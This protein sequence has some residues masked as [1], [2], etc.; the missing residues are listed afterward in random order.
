MK[1]IIF[2]SCIL[3]VQLT[4]AQDVIF[5]FDGTTIESKVIAIE[6]E[7]IKY[8][9]W[10]S[11][12]DSIYSIPKTEVIMINYANG[13]RDMFVNNESATQTPLFYD[14]N[15]QLEYDKESFSKLRLGNKLLTER[16]AFLLLS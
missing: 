11:E 12:E 5:I 2:L 14:A 3:F 7:V 1:K 6:S 16:E 13:N 8:K 4:K 9:L 10:N 15:E